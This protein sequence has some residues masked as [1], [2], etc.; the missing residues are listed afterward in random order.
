MQLLVL[1]GRLF[2]NAIIVISVWVIPV[3]V[4]RLP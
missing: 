3:T 1:P 2:G 4:R